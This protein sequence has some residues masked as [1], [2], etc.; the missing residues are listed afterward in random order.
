MSSK[1]PPIEY[2]GRT[3]SIL[4]LTAVQVLMGIIHAFSGI[5]LLTSENWTALQTSALY[6]VYTLIFGVL[7]FVFAVLIWQGKK[8]GWIGTFAV[9][10]FA[11]VADGLVLFN[12]P[13]IPGIPKELT[14]ITISYSVLIIVCL[15]SNRVRKKF[16]INLWDG[17]VV[18]QS[19]AFPVTQIAGVVGYFNLGDP[20]YPFIAVL[21]LRHKLEGIAAFNRYN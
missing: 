3:L 18:G 10:I 2:K 6:E 16:L 13:S 14:L 5:L 11:A 12:L 15:L 1:H 19:A 4:T 9:S 17:C 8:A 7:I 21:A 20:L